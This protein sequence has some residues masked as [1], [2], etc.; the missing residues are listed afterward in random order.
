MP[1]V[2]MEWFGHQIRVNRK[3]SSLTKKKKVCIRARVCNS[4]GLPIRQQICASSR[5]VWE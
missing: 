3:V 2:K 5:P 4:P 1:Q